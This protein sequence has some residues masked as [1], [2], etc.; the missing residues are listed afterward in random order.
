MGGLVDLAGRRVVVLDGRAVVG[1]TLVVDRTRV[2][3]R[4]LVVLEW[5]VDGE[6]AR[7]GPT[8]Y[9]VVIV[10]VTTPPSS[11]SGVSGASG[12]SGEL[13][14]P[15]PG[16]T[17]CEYHSF[18]PLQYVPVWQAVGPLQSRPPPVWVA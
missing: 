8:L 17:H 2:V 3:D 12:E 5:C 6:E 13:P 1:R 15:L 16:A 14:L 10:C 18:P 7:A 9:S 11:S 4:G